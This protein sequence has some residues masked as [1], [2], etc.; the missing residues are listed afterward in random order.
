MRQSENNFSESIHCGFWDRTQV[1]R[2][3][4]RYLYPLRGLVCPISK[5]ELKVSLCIHNAINMCKYVHCV[6]IHAVCY[7]HTCI[8]FVYL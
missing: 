6:Y 8:Y 4:S 1:L 3:A 2:L 5:L 7:V